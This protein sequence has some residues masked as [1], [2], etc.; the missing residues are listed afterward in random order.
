MEAFG[1]FYWSRDRRRSRWVI[2]RNRALV[3]DDT[4]SRLAAKL[5][6][7]RAD[8]TKTMPDAIQ[9]A[10]LRAIAPAVTAPRA[11][12]MRMTSGSQTDWGCGPG[13][14]PS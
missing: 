4:P 3:S 7:G 11:K 5:V 13:N 12:V 8:Q 10:G 14:F 9:N 6:R 2:S 1:V